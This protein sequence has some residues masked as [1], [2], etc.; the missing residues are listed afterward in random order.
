MPC[1]FSIPGQLGNYCCAWLE[2]FQFQINITDLEFP[3][4]KGNGDH[5]IYYSVQV[6]CQRHIL[7]HT[8]A[9]YNITYIATTNGF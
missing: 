5:F 8:E 4:K 7:A 6:A 1:G 3:V 2:M 9:M